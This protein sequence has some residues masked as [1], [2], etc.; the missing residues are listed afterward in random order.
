[1]KPQPT[2][3][4]KQG[5]SILSP[6]SPPKPAEAAKGCTLQGV[7]LGSRTIE[8]C[9]RGLGGAEPTAYVAVPTDFNC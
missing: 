4:R 5:T 8:S 2:Y 1:M 9:H 3:S 7:G 6:R